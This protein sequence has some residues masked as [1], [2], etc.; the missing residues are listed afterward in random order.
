MAATKESSVP[1]EYNNSASSKVLPFNPENSSLLRWCNAALTPPETCAHTCSV[2]Y[3]MNEISADYWRCIL[4]AMAG[5]YKLQFF[6]H[7][8]RDGML[9]ES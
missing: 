9:G 5:Q 7:Q 6:L 3:L 4:D 2:K 8:R 1:R